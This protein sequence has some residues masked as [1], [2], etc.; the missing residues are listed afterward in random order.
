MNEWKK[1]RQVSYRNVKLS[2]RGIRYIT[3]ELRARAHSTYITHSRNALRQ[4]GTKRTYNQARIKQYRTRG[5]F[6]VRVSRFRW[7]FDDLSLYRH[8]VS[9]SEREKFSPSCTELQ[10]YLS[11]TSFEHKW[12]YVCNKIQIHARLLRQIIFYC[13]KYRLVAV[14]KVVTL[15]HLAVAF[16]KNSR[17]ECHADSGFIR[18]NASD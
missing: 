12:T 17:G 16:V 11:F 1:R 6:W 2:Y 5:C 13:A 4:I 7:R 18:P 8:S 3:S 15:I 10:L 9:S 14:S